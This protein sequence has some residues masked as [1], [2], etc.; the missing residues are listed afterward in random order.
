MSTIFRTG[1][2]IPG[3]RSLIPDFDEVEPTSRFLATG[4]GPTSAGQCPI[5]GRDGIR[6]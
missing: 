3:P 5:L 6:W 4:V 1:H 2:Q